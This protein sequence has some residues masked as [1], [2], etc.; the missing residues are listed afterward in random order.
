M[1]LSITVDPELLA[2]AQR[3]SGTKSKTGTIELALKEL[4]A[5]RGIETVLALEGSDVVD[6]D[7]EEF[8][9]WRHQTK[10]D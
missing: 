2:K 9:R 8:D 6:W 3:L 10:T 5:R 1:R 4:V 7:P